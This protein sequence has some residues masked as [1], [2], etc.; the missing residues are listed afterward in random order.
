M[1][2]SRIFCVLVVAVFSLL[3]VL[4]PATP[5]LAQPEITLSPSS[6]AVGTKVTITG[7]HFESFKNTEIR[8]FFDNVEI[9]NSPLFVPDSG[10]FTTY[11][12]VPAEA[13]PG[14]A[15]VK[16][17]T[18]LGGEVQ[19]SFVVQESEIELHPG[20]G[21]VGTAVTINGRGFYAG[22]TVT[23]YYKGG[24]TANLGTEAV[25]STGEFTYTFSVPDSAAGSHKITV[26]DVLDNSAE[27][28]FKVIPA[29]IVSP[30]GGAMGDK[31]TVSG[32]GFGD[33][34]DVTVY[35][36]NVRMATDDTDKY[37]SSEVAFNVPIIESGTYDI[38]VE[39]G[40]GNKDRAELDVAA[41]ANLSQTAGNVG[42]PL[43]VSGVGFKVGG[44]VTITYDALGVAT[45]TA[46]NN[47]AFS[48]IFNVPASIGG[49][50]TITITDGTT[51]ITQ[52]FT[53]ESTAPPVPV[54]LLP[55][56]ASKARAEVYF[57]WEKVDD[58]SGVTYTLQVASDADFST[59]VLQKEGLT[60]SDYFIIEEE[61]LQPT[62]KEAP[63]YWRVKAVDGASNEGTWSTPRSLY[64]GSSF[65]LP[66]GVLY[67]LIGIGVVLL[68]FLAFWVGRRTAYYQP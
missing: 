49:N 66:S 8:I 10:T 9:G 23:A 30:S 1:K 2:Y 62:L 3:V 32:S 12:N 51:T 5:A 60:G 28:S 25:N 64:V 38:E 55:E 46:G 68:G 24:A 11:F 4:I 54:L 56:D 26:E 67:A 22:G 59:I 16:V 44:T 31:V 65:T 14:V 21:V 57:D 29:I 15:Y 39:D 41:G 42:T 61:A 35:L 36:D 52:I 6:G 63:Y 33:R 48:I 19:K 43:T 37:C 50:H 18:V 27:A 58:P 13:D 20:D 34:S 45:A 53:V 17:S 47:G 7:A 40:D